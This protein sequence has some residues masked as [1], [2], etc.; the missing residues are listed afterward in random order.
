MPAT[1]ADLAVF[2][3]GIP[4][5]CIF[6]YDFSWDIASLNPRLFSFNPPG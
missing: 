5:G 1:L 4:S 2:N 3:S 6:F